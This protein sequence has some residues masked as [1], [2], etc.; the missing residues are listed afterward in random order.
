[1]TWH[2]GEITGHEIDPTM[3]DDSDGLGI[4]GI[5]F[6]PTAAEAEKRRSKRREQVA[7]WRRREEREE[8]RR[9][10]EKRRGVAEERRVG[11]GV[12]FAVGDG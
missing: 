12:R 10:A 5:G 3:P 2:P 8:R 7:E 1:M 11:R 6:E 4:N 9:R